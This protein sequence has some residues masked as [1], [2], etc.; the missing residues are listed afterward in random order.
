MMHQGANLES[1]TLC[2]A[3]LEANSV[4]CLSALCLSQD[5]ILAPLK[6]ARLSAREVCSRDSDSECC[7]KSYWGH[8]LAR[9]F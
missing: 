7:A 1:C 2:Q 5:C 6:R 3:P 4:V 8:D 9:S